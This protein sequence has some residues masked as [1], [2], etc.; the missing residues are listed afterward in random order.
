MSGVAVLCVWHDVAGPCLSR[1]IQVSRIV[2][3]EPMQ[4]E[5]VPNQKEREKTEKSELFYRG[6]AANPWRYEVRP[7][8]GRSR[9][10]GMSKEPAKPDVESHKT[11]SGCWR[12]CR[13]GRQPQRSCLLMVP[14]P[15]E[16]VQLQYSIYRI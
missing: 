6:P 8:I 11:E 12:F 14:G 9:L 16:S 2:L 5:S 15:S 4:S 7:S 10:Y 1:A 3:S 13:Y